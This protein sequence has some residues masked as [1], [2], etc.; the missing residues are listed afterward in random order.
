MKGLI[1]LQIDVNKIID[2]LALQ[3][4]ELTK[5][6]TILQ[7]ENSELKTQLDKKALKEGE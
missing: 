5:N 3:I 1:H 7:V 2:A 6:L 4:A